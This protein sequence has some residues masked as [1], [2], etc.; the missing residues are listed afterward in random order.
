[1]LLR[2][3]L[4]LERADAHR[5]LTATAGIAELVETTTSLRVVETDPDDDRFLELAVDGRADLIVSGD[6]HLLDL[7]E[8]R[9][10]PIRRT[11][12]AL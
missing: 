8:F 1:V 10:I 9:G 6:R 12:D 5:A 7:K 2:P 3:K 11:A 4:R